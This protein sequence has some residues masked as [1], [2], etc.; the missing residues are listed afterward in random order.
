MAANFLIA[1][2]LSVPGCLNGAVGGL[3]FCSAWVRYAAARALVSTLEIPGN[4]QCWGENSTVSHILSCP[5]AIYSMGT[6]VFHGG[7]EVPSVDPV[8]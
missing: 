7:A 3:D 2:V 1:C 8:W 5:G 6:V 4:L